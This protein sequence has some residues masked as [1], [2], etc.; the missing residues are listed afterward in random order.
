MNHWFRCQIDD[1]LTCHK[2][3]FETY[4]LNLSKYLYKSKFDEPNKIVDVKDND[5]FIPF[6][7]FNYPYEK[8]IDYFLRKN[9]YK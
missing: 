3:K 7:L 1:H 4:G 9:S 8:S 5:L 6:G 2:T